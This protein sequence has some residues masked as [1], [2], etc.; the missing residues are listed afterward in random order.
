[1]FPSHRNTD[2]SFLFFLIP[3]PAILILG[4]LVLRCSF[5]A[6]ISGLGD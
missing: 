5:V 4:V 2:V 1:M 3:V 6:G